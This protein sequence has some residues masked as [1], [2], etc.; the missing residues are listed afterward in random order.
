VYQ[1]QKV[2]LSCLSLSFLP[3]R[4][5]GLKTGEDKRQFLPQVH[6]LDDPTIK[7]KGLHW[8]NYKFILYLPFSNKLTGVVT[9]WMTPELAEPI[10]ILYF[11]FGCKS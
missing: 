7:S 9:P 10:Y 6:I 2:H 8:K 3:R 11:Q 1:E 5:R 4:S